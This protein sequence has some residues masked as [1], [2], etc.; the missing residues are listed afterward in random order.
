MDS[1]SNFEK[2]CTEEKKKKSIKFGVKL[3]IRNNSSYL[4]SS[5]HVLGIMQSV[6]HILA[7]HFIFLLHSQ[8]VYEVGVDLINPILQLRKGR[9]NEMKQVAYGNGDG[10]W[11]CLIGILIC[12]LSL[13]NHS[14]LD[15]KEFWLQREK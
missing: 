3:Y 13:L 15:Y 14:S 9:L 1:S 5:Y 2:E 12:F 10:G 7:P 4:L 11:R 6:L 8:Q